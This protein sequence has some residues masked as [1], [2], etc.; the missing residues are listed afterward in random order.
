MLTKIDLAHARN[1][2]ARCRTQLWLETEV[3][4]LT[5]MNVALAIERDGLKVKLRETEAE[6]EAVE[7]ENRRATAERVAAV[8]EVEKRLAQAHKDERERDKQLIEQLRDAVR[9]KKRMASE[10][11][12]KERK[13]GVMIVKN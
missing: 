13:L 6:L 1:E 11:V 4:V 3:G 8:R 7:G 5:D 12:E 2:L 9:G 10:L